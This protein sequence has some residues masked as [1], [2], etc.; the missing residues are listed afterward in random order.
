MMRV[1]RLTLVG[2]VM[3]AQQQAVVCAAGADGTRQ[4]QARIV[5]NPG[6]YHPPNTPSSAWT[7]NAVLCYMDGRSLPGSPIFRW[8][9]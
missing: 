1:G 7:T 5:S 8:A 6:G 9:K 2:V 3:L 4:Q